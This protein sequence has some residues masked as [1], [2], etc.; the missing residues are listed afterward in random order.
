MY[1]LLPRFF[2]DFLGPVAEL[3]AGGQSLPED[4]RN[5]ESQLVALEKHSGDEIMT[6]L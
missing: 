4:C 5:L 3:D 2:V 1:Q 6:G